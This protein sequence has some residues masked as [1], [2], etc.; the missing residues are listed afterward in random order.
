MNTK[1]H[2]LGAVIICWTIQMA[3]CYLLFL[4]M[5][6]DGSIS[7]Y[8]VSPFFMIARFFCALVFHISTNAEIKHGL[9]IM[10]F[11]A[12]HS[13]RLESP[14]MVFLAG[15]L[16]SVAIVALSIVN[17]TVIMSS[18]TFLDIVVYFFLLIIISKFP[19]SFYS[20]IGHLAI[21]DMVENPHK[22][23]D[24]FTITRT[25]S[26]NCPV[27]EINSVEDSTFRE[28]KSPMRLHFSERPRGQKV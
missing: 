9:S 8:P 15:L 23:S 13:F 25:T 24:L 20:G 10:K 3:L 2:V 5:I 14:W 17:F 21:K 18:E 19:V 4:Q 26:D 6:A 12:N 22:F 27:N 7:R 28:G 1:G 16:Q 11:A